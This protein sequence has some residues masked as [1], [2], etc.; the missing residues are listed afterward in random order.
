MPAF[1]VGINLIEKEVNHRDTE[2]QRI[3]EHANSLSWSIKIVKNKSG[4]RTQREAKPL[5]NTIVNSE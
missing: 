3:T 2:T 5:T 1:D 4:N